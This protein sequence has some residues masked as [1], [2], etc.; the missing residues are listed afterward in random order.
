MQNTKDLE[1]EENLSPQRGVNLF[2]SPF[3]KVVVAHSPT[4]SMHKTAASWKGLGKKLLLHVI[5]D[6]QKT[7]FQEF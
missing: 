7:K 4:P 2:S 1:N 5:G 6:V 3:H